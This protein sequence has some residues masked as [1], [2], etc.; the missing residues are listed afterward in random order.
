MI[1]LWVNK[2]LYDTD[3]ILLIIDIDNNPKRFPTD[4]YKYR[5]MKQYFF[6]VTAVNAL[7]NVG[8]KLKN[9]H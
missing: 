8:V 2:I 3:R 5:M 7:I 6:Y 9:S 4:G 1:A